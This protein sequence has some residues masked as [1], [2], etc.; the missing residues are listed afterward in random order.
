VLPIITESDDE[1]ASFWWNLHANVQQTGDDE[2]KLTRLFSA[3]TPQQRE[4]LRQSYQTDI[5][6]D[7]GYEGRVDENIQRKAIAV[8]EQLQS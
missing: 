5:D 4:D 8:L 6:L 1:A 3:L 7:L 2:E